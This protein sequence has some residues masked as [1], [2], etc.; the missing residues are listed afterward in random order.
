MSNVR[1]TAEH[2][3]ESDSLSA[4]AGRTVQGVVWTY[5][6]LVGSRLVTFVSMMVLA[7]MLLPSAFGQ[8]GFALLVIAYLDALGDLG[9]G[10]ALIYYQKRTTEAAQIAFRINLITGVLWCF[11]VTALAPLA[12]DFFHDEIVI[13]LLRTL[14]W[15]FPIT[16][17]G[18]THDAILRRNLSFGLRLVPDYARSLLKAACSVVLAWQGFGVWSLVWGQ[19][20]GAAVWSL[21]LWILIGWR[22]TFRAPMSLGPSMLRYGGHIVSINI[23][24]TLVHHLDLLVVGRI[25]GSAALGFYTLASRIPDVCITMLIWA[26]DIVAFPSYTKLQD[27]PAILRQAFRF[28]LRYISVITL[29]AGLGLIF[30][31]G[32]AISILYGERWMPAASVVVGLS[33]AAVLRSLSSHAGNIFKAIGRPDLLTKIGVARAMVLMPALVYGAHYGIAGVALAQAAVT[34]ASTLTTLILAARFLRIPPS[35]CWNELRPALIG[36]IGMGLILV[37]TDFLMVGWPPVA[38]LL[39]AAVSGSIGYF[40]ILYLGSPDMVRSISSGISAVLGR[41]S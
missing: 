40:G 17:L 41:S 21:T 33:L 3:S 26:I 6:A 14:A 23:L 18:N 36:S 32:P 37:I 22:P 30:C 4:W 13:P 19:L 31:A 29:P 7:R 15:I 20:A 5:A 9:A 34:F 10:S 38:I 8:L 11:A 12:A 27:D 25:L 28:T 35:A 1:I 16:S 39:T 24:S 2:H